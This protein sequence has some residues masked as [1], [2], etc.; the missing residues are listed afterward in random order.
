MGGPHASGDLAGATLFAA[1]VAVPGGAPYYL[2][3]VGPEN[4]VEVEV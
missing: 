4:V 1:Y 2:K 3:A